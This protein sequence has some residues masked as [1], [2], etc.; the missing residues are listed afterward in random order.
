M[1]LGRALY[2][3]SVLGFVGF[4]FWYTQNPKMFWFLF[5]IILVEA[6]DG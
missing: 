3:I 6:V 5:L 4:L 2:L 1:K